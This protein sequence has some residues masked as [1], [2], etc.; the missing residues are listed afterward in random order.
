MLAKSFLFA[1]AGSVLAIVITLFKR[2]KHQQLQQIQAEEKEKESKRMQLEWQAMEQR[3][4]PLLHIIKDAAEAT[5]K[6]PAN[7]SNN[8][9]EISV[10]PWHE[11][12]N[13]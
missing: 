3:R 12:F 11:E 8:Q 9:E 13:G 2:H 5:R 4:Q 10:L 1:L 6:E 7:N